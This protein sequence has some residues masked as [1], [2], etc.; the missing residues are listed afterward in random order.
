MLSNYNRTSS[1]VT[2]LFW[3]RQPRG[4]H[5][6]RRPRRRRHWSCSRR[7][8]KAREAA[9]ISGS[10]GGKPLRVKKTGG[11]QTRHTRLRQQQQLRRRRRFSR[12]SGETQRWLPGESSPSHNVSLMF[13]FYSESTFS[14]T[15]RI[16]LIHTLECVT[17]R[18][19]INFEKSN[20]QYFFRISPKKLN[21]C[22]VKCDLKLYNK[23]PW[24]CLKK[25]V[26]CSHFL[27]CVQF[28]E[29]KISIH[30]VFTMTS[31][32]PRFNS[33]FALLALLTKFPSVEAGYR[34]YK[35]RKIVRIFF[36]RCV[37]K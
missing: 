36:Y 13:V 9:C 21:C 28:W 16:E 15:I 1:I 5:R 20:F 30:S 11:P 31:I 33:S 26:N 35:L 18:L 14:W 17:A 23:N 29:D 3:W 4:R 2:V 22:D 6:F 34:I 19:Q 25:S 10:C 27:F 7:R 24:Q 37:Y 12:F 8:R 32:V